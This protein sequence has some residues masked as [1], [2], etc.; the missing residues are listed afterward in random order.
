MVVGVSVE[1]RLCT[2]VYPLIAPCPTAGE[3]CNW[4]SPPQENKNIKMSGTKKTEQQNV[5]SQENIP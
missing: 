5:Q 4:E 2:I 3:T 1:D